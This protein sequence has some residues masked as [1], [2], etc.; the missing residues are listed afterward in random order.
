MSRLTDL[1][2]QAK[3]KDPQMGMDL[4]REFKSEQGEKYG[5]PVSVR[6]RI[7]QSSF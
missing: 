1:I 3:A 4:E 6:P 2:T 7:G 5:A